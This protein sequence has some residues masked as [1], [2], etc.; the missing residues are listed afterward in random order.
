MEFTVIGGLIIFVGLFIG[1]G[2]F[3]YNQSSTPSFVSPLI[4]NT[5]NPSQLIIPDD[6]NDS[7]SPND[8]ILDNTEEKYQC[9]FAKFDTQT[10]ECHTI[11]DEDEKNFCY[12]AQDLHS[13]QA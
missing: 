2:L 9:Y 1:I 11:L 7:D 12:V 4:S 3:L 13:L 5:E 6:R 10:V 8:C